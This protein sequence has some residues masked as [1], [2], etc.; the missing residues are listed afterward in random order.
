MAKIMAAMRRIVPK[1]YRAW[2]RL[3]ICAGYISTRCRR[4]AAANYWHVSNTYFAGAKHPKESDMFKHD[5][6][7]TTGTKSKLARNLKAVAAFG[8]LAATL[9]GCVVYPDGGYY[10]GGYGYAPAPAYYAPPVAFDFGFGG[11]YYGHR[12]WR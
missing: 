5:M 9:S 12:G 3:H 4:K 10:G 2:T 8:L 1:G 6:T 11:G 7:K